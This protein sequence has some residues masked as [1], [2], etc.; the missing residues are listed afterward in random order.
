MRASSG[1]GKLARHLPP[2][3][4]VGDEIAEAAARLRSEL[5]AVEQSRGG[6]QQ[7][8]LGGAR[9]TMDG[10][11]GL[12]AESALGLVDDPLER[13]VVGGLDDQ[14]QVGDGVADLG[15]LV[16]AEAA[17]D[18]VGQ[19][20]RDEALFELAGLELGAD[21]DRDIVERAA[22][23][24]L[25]F[26]FLADAPRFFGAVPDADDADLFAFAGVGPQG[27]AEPAGIV[28]DEAVGGGEDVRLV[29][30]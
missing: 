30:R 3:G 16:K 18:L 19:A 20:D 2:A 13:E 23:T 5:V 6:E 4:D 28:G 1:C 25:E 24:H 27:L 21:E 7:R 15:A 10:R 11:D 22:A 26:G 8:L 14:A 12:V 17:D 9:V 29:E